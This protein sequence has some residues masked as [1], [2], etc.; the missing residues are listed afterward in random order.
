MS[1]EKSRRHSSKPKPPFVGCVELIPHPAVCIEFVDAHRLWAFP[2]ADL[3]GFVL[4]ENPEHRDKKTQPPEQMVLYYNHSKVVLKG[5]RLELLAGQLVVGRVARIH[6]EGHLGPLMIQEAWVSE[7][8][9]T[10]F[11]H[12]VGHCCQPARPATPT[13]IPIVIKQ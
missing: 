2:L 11:G 5:W 10:L 12:C 6:S 4:E 3:A 7:I 1:P 13:E 8:Q 9:V